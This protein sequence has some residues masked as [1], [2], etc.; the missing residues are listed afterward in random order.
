MTVNKHQRVAVFVDVQNM[1]YSAKYQYNGK[2]N[3]DKLLDETIRGRKLIR[4]LA[5]LVQTEDI[6]QSKFQDFLYSLGYE[7][8]NKQLRTRPDGSAKG[9]WDMGIAIDAIAV[10]ERVDVV[11][12]VSGDG[13]F[14]D[15]VEM[16]KGNGVRVEVY[17]FP[18]STADELKE[19]A[20]EYYDMAEDYLL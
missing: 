8:K 17:S 11:C 15:L 18:T 13:D 2:V 5:Y 3:F 12:L 9:D 10:G 4:A 7:V 20:T 19:A 6:D 16:L 1:Y 14:V